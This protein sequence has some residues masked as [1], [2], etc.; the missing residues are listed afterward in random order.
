MR[1]RQTEDKTKTKALA[2]DKKVKKLKRALKMMFTVFYIILFLSESSCPNDLCFFVFVFWPFFL[3]SRLIPLL[4]MPMSR[5]RKVV[6][7]DVHNK[8]LP[9]C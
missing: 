6:G 3:D 7:S 8:Y 5:C 9:I 4:S 1:E 2:R